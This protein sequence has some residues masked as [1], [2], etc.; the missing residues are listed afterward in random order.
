VRTRAFKITTAIMVL[1]VVGLPVGIHLFGAPSSLRTV[2]LTPANAAMAAPVVGAARTV[3]QEVKVRTLPDV[4]TG[5][6]ELASG[7]LDALLDG[8][9][10]ALTVVANKGLVS[11]QEDV[12]AVIGPILMLIIVPYVV[13]VRVLPIDPENGLARVLSL[14]PFF[15]PMLMP[16]RT[17][18]GVAPWWEVAL[19]VALTGALTG[20]LVGLSAR[21]YRNSV[22]RTGARVP[23]RDALRAS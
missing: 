18:L 10:D 16:M 1:A 3:G 12:G 4:P 14:I 21:V 17:A 9:P 23:V 19:T 13:G 8:A 7:R 15:S 20:G 6:R 5:E 11:R 2:G 22:M